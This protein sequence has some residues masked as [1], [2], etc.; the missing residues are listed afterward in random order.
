MKVKFA[1]SVWPDRA[2]TVTIGAGSK[3]G[4][5]VVRVVI[6]ETQGLQSWKFLENA[7]SQGVYGRF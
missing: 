4:Y 6:P 3:R 7:V 2:V 1:K 5:K